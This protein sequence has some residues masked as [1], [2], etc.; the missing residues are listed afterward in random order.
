MVLQAVLV[1]VIITLA[2]IVLLVL[3]YSSVKEFITSLMFY[4]RFKRKSEDLISSFVCMSLFLIGIML[5]ALFI[6]S[7]CYQPIGG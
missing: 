3:V 5:M 2:A 7:S 6:L 4:F 1:G